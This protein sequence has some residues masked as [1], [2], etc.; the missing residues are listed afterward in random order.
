VSGKF[1]RYRRDFDSSGTLQAL[2]EL[3]AHL[4]AEPEADLA[5]ARVRLLEALGPNVGLAA[6]LVPALGLLLEVAPEMP[7]GDSKEVEARI[8][9]A[10]LDILH[11]VVS[12]ARPV[13]MVV[14][15]LQWS[16]PISIAF[17]E[18]VLTDD[19][20]AGLLLLGA[21]RDTDVDGAQPSP[22]IL[23]R[24]E[25]L[26]VA[27]PRLQLRNLQPVDVG[28]LLQEMLRLPAEQAAGLAEA[29][30][31]R[32]GGNPFD[33][34]QLV[35]A[36]RSDGAL[37]L[38]PQGWTWDPATIRHWIGRGDVVDLLSVRIDALPPQARG[39][40]EVMATLGGELDYATL[41]VASGLSGDL[42][43]AQLAP[44]LEDG[45]IVLDRSGEGVGADSARF[46]HDRVQEAALDRLEPVRRGELHLVLARRLAV[47]R[48]LEAMAAE[49]YSHVDG[50]I[51]GPEERRRVVDFLREGA[52][53]LRV[54]DHPTTERY[55]TTGLGLLRS[56][57]TEADTTLITALEMDLH[58]VLCDLGRLGESDDLFA[59]L[60]SR[61]LD[62]LDLVDAAC[63]QMASLHVR[64][65][66]AE[67]VGLGLDLLSKLGTE[68]PEDVL[69]AVAE[70][71]DAVTRWVAEADRG[72]DSRPEISDPVLLAQAKLLDKLVQPAF[73][74]DRAA[75]AW[76]GLESQR[77]WA[78]HGPCAPLIAGAGATSALHIVMREDYRTAYD[79]AR[80]AIAVGEAHGYEPTTSYVRVMHATLVEQWFE[81]VENCI[82]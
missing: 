69:A 82:S 17:L 60:A 63:V 54:T 80:N 76:L 51:L 81:P 73:F 61:G 52:K 10:G 8:L 44:A 68:L 42:L 15:D 34:L 33:T 66:F 7:S 5:S 37:S 32:T 35:N 20:L 74:V 13:V 41:Q 21:Y 6:A 59:S 77:V 47:S 30:G 55:L 38:G 53:S 36:L 31:Q 27:P 46:G 2:R 57:Q 43:Q 78:E 26:G 58:S 22:A 72:G 48:E 19:A 11:A 25:D 56:V 79:L 14:D 67:A 29:I 12:P 65:R 18:A 39:L 70:R 50:Q 40:L 28:R 45:L 23:A 4:L 62:P 64:T 49:Q 3:C 9:R 16:R 24:W 1:D 75:C 71:L